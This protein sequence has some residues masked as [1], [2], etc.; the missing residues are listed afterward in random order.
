MN[1]GVENKLKQLLAEDKIWLIYIGI[2][3]LSWF[4]NSLERKY[5]VFNDE[6]SKE[7]YRK[8]M[9]FIFSVLIIV[10]FYFLKSSLNDIKNIKPTD[11]ERKKTLVYLSFFGSFFILV[12]GL[13]FLFIALVDDDLSVELAFN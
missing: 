2:I 10:Y 3:F 1:R 8:V 7:K 13:I 11:S 6:I 12:S 5:F 9:I 4:A